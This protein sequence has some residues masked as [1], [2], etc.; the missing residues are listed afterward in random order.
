MFE[1]AGKSGLGERL[2]LPLS[3]N[4][5]VADGVIG[6]TVLAQPYDPSAILVPPVAGTERWCAVRG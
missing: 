2:I 4:G 5:E 3:E 1:I 6:I